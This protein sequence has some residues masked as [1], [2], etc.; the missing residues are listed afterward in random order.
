MNWFKKKK[1]EDKSPRL[2]IRSTVYPDGKV[3][4]WYG[5]V[6]KPKKLKTVFDKL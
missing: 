4:K 2:L 1:K 5:A 3:L 6:D